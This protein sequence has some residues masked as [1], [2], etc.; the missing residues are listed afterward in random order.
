MQEKRNRGF[1]YSPVASFLSAGYGSIIQANQKESHA[2]KNKKKS[3]FVLT[4]ILGGGGRIKWIIPKSC[5]GEIK[6]GFRRR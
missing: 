5:K 6:D 3:N 2:K 1:P 4:N